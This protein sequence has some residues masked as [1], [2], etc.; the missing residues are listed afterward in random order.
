LNLEKV[1]IAGAP[2]CVA[3]ARLC[4]AKNCKIHVRRSQQLDESARNLLRARVQ[5]GGA[6][7]PKN[8]RRVALI[9]TDK[10]LRLNSGEI[11]SPNTC[12]TAVRRNRNPKN[13][14]M[15]SSPA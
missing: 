1:I 4:V 12:I 13:I 2:R 6:P 14:I 11:P 7:D 10:A 15:C 5:S 8:N 9:G 3:R